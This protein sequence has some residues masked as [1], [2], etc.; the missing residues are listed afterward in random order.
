MVS[1]ENTPP[2]PEALVRLPGSSQILLSSTGTDDSLKNVWKMLDRGLSS[3][4]FS[5][6]DS[7]DKGEQESNK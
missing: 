4:L 3:S 5:P 7:E 6:S 2:Q 1:K